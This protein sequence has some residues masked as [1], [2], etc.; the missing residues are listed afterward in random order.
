[1]LIPSTSLSTIADW[2]GPKPFD[3]LMI[4]SVE[5]PVLSGVEGSSTTYQMHHRNIISI[6]N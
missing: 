1:M 4:H 2:H 5:G 3:W 6:F